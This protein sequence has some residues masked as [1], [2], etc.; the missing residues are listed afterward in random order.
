MN[1][2]Y[3]KLISILTIVFWFQ[4]NNLG[5]KTTDEQA[6]IIRFNYG[7]TDLTELYALEDE[8]E[9]RLA[10]SSLGEFDGHDIAADGSFVTLFLYG[11]DAKQVYETVK[12][13]LMK[14]SFMNGAEVTLRYGPQEEGVKKKVF[15]IRQGNGSS[16]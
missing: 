3:L 6:L 12:D 1:I 10:S 5:V 15:V 11:T 14:S 13:I 16:P 8:L 9:Q 4:V 2:L 7:S